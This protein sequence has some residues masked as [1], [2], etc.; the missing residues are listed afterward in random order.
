MRRYIWVI[1]II[2]SLMFAGSVLFKRSAIESGNRTVELVLD[3]DSAR[4]F[5]EENDYDLQTFLREVKGAG[6]NS[7]GLTEETLADLVDQGDAVVLSGSEVMTFERLGRLAHPLLAWLVKNNK[8]VAANTYVF[9]ADKESYNDLKDA[10]MIRLEGKR[11]KSW[12]SDGLGVIE[13]AQRKNLSLRFNLG[14]SRDEIEMA[15]AAGLGIIPRFTNARGVT[16][17]VIEGFIRRAGQLDP[18]SVVLFNGTQVA[19]FPDHVKDVASVLMANGIAFGRIEFAKQQ[20]DAELAWFMTPEHIIRVHSITANEI[21]KY[22]PESARER[23][24]RAARERGMR[25]LYIRPLTQFPPSIDPVKGNIE[26]FGSIARSL[27]GEGFHIGIARPYSA[28]DSRFIILLAISLGALA[29][30]ILLLEAF[31]PLPAWAQMLLFGIGILAFTGIYLSFSSTLTRKIV[32]LGA[33]IVYP[34]LGAISV[35]EAGCRANRRH[36]GNDPFGVG[37]DGYSFGGA[38]VRA[39]SIWLSACLMTGVGALIVASILSNLNF[40]LQLDQFAGVKFMHILPIL[41]VAFYM[42]RKKDAFY[43][44]EERGQF[45]LADFLNKPILMWHVLAAALVLVS[46]VIYVGRTGNSFI[47]PISGIEETMR[48]TLERIFIVRPRTKEFLIGHPAMILAALL[49]AKDGLRKN[50]LAA[51]A[52]LVGT[53]GQLSFV[54]SFSHLHTP[55]IVTIMRTFWGAFIGCAGGVV[56]SVIYLFLSRNVRQATSRRLRLEG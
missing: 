32:A 19:G 38:V 21:P 11:L 55:I 17:K 25:I 6:V 34:S 37:K 47:L 26:Y 5:C 29:G 9:S 49:F 51:V 22:M 42:W 18:F 20:G 16:P 41:I 24:I 44:R 43:E 4:A 50:W 2:I 12:E 48:T 13:I 23:F 7:L 56:I 35:I 30:G 39:I 28:F 54:N 14:L 15:K 52:L 33:A 45:G 27:E 8:I 10:L 46:G 53:I 3:L 1:V 31:H 40:M 36:A